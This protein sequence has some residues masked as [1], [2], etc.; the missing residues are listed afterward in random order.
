MMAGVLPGGLLLPVCPLPPDTAG[1]CGFGCGDG[2][3]E[4]DPM[5]RWHGALYL[6]KPQSL[7]IALRSQP[8]GLGQ[9]RP[10]GSA[11]SLGVGG[12]GG[13][14]ILSTIIPRL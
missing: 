13:G 8:L 3:V 5:T 4:A 6:P 2:F 11:G 14:W 9:T 7:S 10:K 12:G 1:L